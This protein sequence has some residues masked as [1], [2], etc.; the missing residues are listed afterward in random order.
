M[1]DKKL[2][3]NPFFFL[4]FLTIG[5]CKVKIEGKTH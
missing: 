4:Q 3:G 2:A 1:V 5:D